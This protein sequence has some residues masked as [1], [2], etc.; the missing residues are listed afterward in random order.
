MDLSSLSPTYVKN[1]PAIDGKLDDECWKSAAVVTD[2]KL[3]GGRGLAG[4]QTI[5]RICYD[6][7]AFYIAVEC[8]EH[9]MEKLTAYYELDDDPVWRDDCV[10][11]FIAPYAVATSANFHHYVVNSIGKK[12]YLMAESLQPSADRWSA[13]ASRAGDR[14]LAEMAIPFD[15]LQPHGLNEPFWRINF[16][17]VD[18]IHGEESA[19][20]E[21]PGR[22]ASFWRFARLLQPDEGHR[23]L[24]CKGQPKPVKFGG[25]PRGAQVI[26]RIP[27]EPYSPPV[28]IPEPVVARHFDGCFRITPVTRILIGKSDDPMDRRP[29]E[30]INE[31]L[32][33]VAG[34]TLPIE[35]VESSGADYANCVI[36]G[37]RSLNPAADDFCLANGIRLSQT[38]PGPEGYAVE[39]K[40]DAILVAGSDQLGTFWGAQTLRQLIKR[41]L[42]GK[43]AVVGCVAVRDRPKFSYRGVHLLVTT[44]ALS[45]HGRL[46]DKVLSRFKINNILLQC[47]HVEWDS[48]PEI[49]NP[50]RAMSKE[51]VRK[52]IEIANDHHIT[53]TPLL[54][55]FGHM[56]WAFYGKHHVDMAED[57]ESPYAYCPLNPKSH[58]FVGKLTDEVIELFGNPEYVHTGRDEYD[59]RGRF[60][61][62]EECARIGKEQLYIDDTLWN[63]NF[64]ADRGAKMMMWGDILQKT[65]Y[66]EKMDQLPRD[67]VICDWR[68]SPIEEYPS[69]DLFMNAGFKVIACT[70]YV[71]KN[72]FHFSLE[73]HKRGIEGMMQT[74]WTGFWPEERV[75]QDE[76]HQIHSYILGA[77]WA[78]S[79]GTP[80][81]EDLP[82]ESDQVFSD[83]WFAADSRPVGS[84]FAVDLEPYLNIRLQ[85]N[86]ERAGW[87]AYGEGYD[88]GG[89]P[90]GA[91]KLEG[92]PYRIS[93][94]RAGVLTGGP[95]GVMD[96]FPAS[97]VGIPV[98]SRANKLYFLHTACFADAGDRKV[99]EYVIN[100]ED[101]SKETV[102]LIYG[103]TIA[104]WDVSRQGSRTRSAWRGQRVSGE[105]IRVNTLIWNN[106]HPDKI[107]SSFDFVSTGAQAAPVLIA[108]TGEVGGD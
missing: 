94:K 101:G 26:T 95:S 78:W 105:I 16:C 60:P 43:S 63:R 50:D 41:D 45:F 69:L 92:F 68:Y 3:T 42:S 81:I 36:V 107:I 103:K 24:T 56:E 38:S 8:L 11:I 35:T 79:P 65:G 27:P 83:L 66:K 77:E 61:V 64:L 100:Y 17:R 93:E 84:W 70:W 99:G 52:L 33:R 1:P 85:D 91:V 39:V 62:H 97:V 12:S 32:Q 13:A 37:E 28:I 5:A 90:V 20:S 98:E 57:R 31:E 15:M 102:P 2:F 58:E 10:E 72:L 19:W 73:G 54:Q 87:L 71:P 40:P 76:F 23:F 74:T 47:E 30:E 75:L 67:I 48:Y 55:T 21:V 86:H 49:R 108:V 46:I 29:A 6:E 9:E 53:V 7:T 34:F 18:L 51:D 88:L 25:E 80:E 22:F 104:A 96:G 44:D 59:M 4:C 89:L 82:Y 14:W 106:P